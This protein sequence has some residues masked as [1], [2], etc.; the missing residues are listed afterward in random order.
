MVFGPFFKKYKYEFPNYFN[1]PTVSVFNIVWF[2]IISQ[3]KKLKY[4][5]TNKSFQKSSSETIYGKIQR[6]KD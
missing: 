6:K 3:L 4:T 1:D 5:F 2:N